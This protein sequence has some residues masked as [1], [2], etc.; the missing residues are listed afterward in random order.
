MTQHIIIAGAGVVGLALA[1]QLARAGGRVT[2]IDPEDPASGASYGNAGALSQGSVAPLAMP[3]VL[4]QVPGMLTDP[5]GALRIPP[6]VLPRV[7]PWLWRFVASAKPARVLE[8]AEALQAL[9]GNAIDHHRMMLAEE[10][11]LDLLRENGQLQLYRD[12][13]GFAKDAGSFSLRRRFGHRF[14]ILRGAALAEFQ[15]GIAPE[16]TLGVLLPDQGSSTNPQR[17]ALTFLRGAQRMGATLQRGRVQSIITEGGRA[18]GVMTDA[19]PLAA[20]HVVL[21]AG[22][23][24]AALLRPLGLSIPLE[25]QRGYH[26]MIPDAGITLERPVVASDRKAFL[27]PMEGGLRVPGT[28]EFGGLKRPPD[29][30]RAQYLLEDVKR[31]FPAARTDSAEPFWMG[32]R[33]CLPDSLPVVGPVARWPGLW[34]AFG[35]GHLGL[36]SSAPTGAVLARAILGPAPNINLAPFAPE[37][38]A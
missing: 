23:W 14:E 25:S 3:G 19:G 1:W 12:E 17:H 28:V 35:H 37:R 27:S 9:Q 13:A 7:L 30:R 16:Y 18:T 15:P 36:T 21:A 24:S 31:V 2:I 4:K 20:D 6:T 11:A 29:P 22:M 38:F 33:P 32:H 10:G 26:V 5:R 8:I 34:C